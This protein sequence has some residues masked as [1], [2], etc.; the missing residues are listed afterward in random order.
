MNK[1]IAAFLNLINFIIIVKKIVLTR[2]ERS[3][4]SVMS[5]YKYDFFYLS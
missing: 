1:M 2:V 4:F 3:V 5:V